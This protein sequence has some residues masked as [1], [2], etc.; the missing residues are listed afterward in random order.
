M[1]NSQF[2]RDETLEGQAEA[3]A[4]T[5]KTA[6]AGA[7]WFSIGGDCLNASTVLRARQI[8]RESLRAK[9]HAL[10]K[11]EGFDGPVVRSYAME[12]F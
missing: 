8:Q 1:T 3:L 7:I 9:S 6:K 4:K 12:V 5:V 11:R 10:W 2:Q